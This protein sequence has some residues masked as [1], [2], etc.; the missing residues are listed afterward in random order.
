MNTFSKHYCASHVW[1]LLIPCIS[2]SMIL[3]TVTELRSETITNA[4]ATETPISQTLPPPPS[5]PPPNHTRSGGSLGDTDACDAGEPLVAL[6]P[7][8][9]PVLTTTDDPTILL[10]VP[11]EAESIAVGEFS[12][13]V[14]VDEMTRLYHGQFTLPPTPGIVS[15]SLPPRPDYALAEGVPYHWY[16]KLHCHNQTILTVDAWI[17]QSTAPEQPPWYDTLAEMA[18]RLQQNPTDPQLRQQWQALLATIDA[19]HLAEAPLLG[20]VTWLP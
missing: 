10:Y 18:D 11:D 6:V 5:T 12:V 2:L 13:L 15:L 19:D 14:G 9:N 7:V 1:R 16:V 8:N 3:G 20:A 17:Q 4:A